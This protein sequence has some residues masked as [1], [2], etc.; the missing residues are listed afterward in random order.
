M[1][2]GL[3]LVS[4]FSTYKVLKV[5]HTDD[6]EQLGFHYLA[7]GHLGMVIGARD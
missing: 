1:V 4:G 2:N 5:L 6:A 7:Q 3:S